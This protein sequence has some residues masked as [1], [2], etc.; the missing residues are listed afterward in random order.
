MTRLLILPA[1]FVLATLLLWLMICNAPDWESS[2]S[3]QIYI[4][5]QFE[6]FTIVAEQFRTYKQNH[7]IY[8]TLLFIFTYLYKQTFAIPGSFVLN[9]IAG[10]VFGMWTGFLMCCAL[11]TC[12]SSLCYMFSEL[13]SRE[14]VLYYFGERI[15]YLQQKVDDNSHRLLP[16]LLFARMFPISP[17]WLLNIIAPFL[18]IPLP[19]F[20]FSALI[21]LAPYN[22]ICVQAGYILSDL[23]SW[24]DVF[25]TS[26]MFKLCS[27]ALL[28]LA[29]AMFMRHPSRT[30]VSNSEPSRSCVPFWFSSITTSESKTNLIDGEEDIMSPKKPTDLI[31]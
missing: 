28:P 15:T 22:F 25:S 5:T 11:T 1:I 27:F 24:E 10:A 20:A 31:V 8:I 19:I 16:F 12:G 18:N 30:Q 29:Y 21:G 9:I 23:Q 2:D 6:N 14:Y 4:P 7:Y 3:S 13:F 17:S 26:T